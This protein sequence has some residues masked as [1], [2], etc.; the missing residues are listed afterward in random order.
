MTL[1]TYSYI[2]KKMRK[3]KVIIFTNRVFLKDGKEK[4]T[5][6]TSIN[7]VLTPS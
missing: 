7:H 5:R 4:V 2:T 1:S 6:Q 3:K